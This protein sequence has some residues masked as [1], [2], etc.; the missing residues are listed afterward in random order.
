VQ[1]RDGNFYGTTRQGGTNNSGTVFKISS[2]GALTSL[3]SFGSANSG[4]FP[5]TG[6]VQGSDGYLYGTT[7]DGGS[8]NDG[9]VYKIST[10]GTLTTL[11]SFTYGNDGGTP[12]AGLVQ[13]SDGYFYGT[14]VGGGTNDNGTVF[15]ISTN[16]VLTSL[17]S[18]TGDKDG[19]WPEAGLVEGSD[20][21][22]YG[23]TYN[24][25]VGGAGT[26]FRLT[27]VPE[28]PQLAITTSGANIILTWSADATG[29]NLEF[30]ANL[31]PPV[32]WQTN[33][34]APIIL[35]DQNTV[36]IPITGSQMFF[37]LTQ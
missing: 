34:T 29:F 12:W 24:A 2:D 10:T 14:T 5:Q 27:I 30:A 7:A 4:Y 26:V 11:H 3:Y 37:R 9:T 15:K 21:S 20:G 36:A 31:A 17:Y 35:N 6:L 22:F 33:S 25:G 18:F 16:G 23:T 32:A 8:N 19:E 1:G 28:P 13:G